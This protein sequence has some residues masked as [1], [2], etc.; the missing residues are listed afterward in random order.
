[1]R[2]CFIERHISGEYLEMK[3][4]SQ[5]KKPVVPTRGSAQSP[6]SDEIAAFYTYAEQAREPKIE[7]TTSIERPR[8]SPWLA[9]GNGQGTSR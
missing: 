6:L 1:M 8:I 3:C 2:A 9:A 5:L 7:P 4:N